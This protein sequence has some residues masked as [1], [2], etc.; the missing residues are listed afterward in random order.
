MNL[1]KTN[2]I[3]ANYNGLINFKKKNFLPEYSTKKAK[4]KFDK[5]LKKKISN[6]IFLYLVIISFQ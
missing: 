1:N 4:I 5:I 3:I 6:N 2:S